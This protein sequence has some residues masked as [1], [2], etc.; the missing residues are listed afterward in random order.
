M[1][2]S[3]NMFALLFS[4][5]FLVSGSHA[6]RTTPGEKPT[7]WPRPNP[8]DKDTAPQMARWMAHITTWGTLSTAKDGSMPVGGIVSHSDGPWERPSPRL[9]FYLTPMDE[10]VQIITTNPR[11]SYTLTEAS[12]PHGCNGQDPEDPAC[13]K[14][15]LLGSM[16]PVSEKDQELAKEAMFSRHPAME[17]WPTGHH[18]QLWELK[19]EEIHLL[20]WYGGMKIITGKDYYDATLTN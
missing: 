4:V 11:V 20:D 15:A 7:Q 18:F 16:Q 5:L 12:L 3:C 9:F 10:L 19:V 8:T 1:N 2:K 14:A 6:A 17:A 13:A